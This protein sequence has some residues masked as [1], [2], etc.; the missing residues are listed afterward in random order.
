M[1]FVVSLVLSIPP[2]F[3][4][5]NR[6]PL[7]GLPPDLTVKKRMVLFLRK[8]RGRQAMAVAGAGT[9]S[10][11]LQLARI[12]RGNLWAGVVVSYGMLAFCAAVLPGAMRLAGRSDRRAAG[13]MQRLAVRA[14]S[15]SP[16]F[17]EARAGDRFMVLLAYLP[18]ALLPQVF[19]LRMGYFL[20]KYSLVLNWR[21]AVGETLAGYAVLVGPHAVMEIAALALLASIPLLVYVEVARF[22]AG[23]QGRRAA[24]LAKRALGLR[25]SACIFAAGAAVLVAAAV[26]ETYASDK[27]YMR[28]DRGLLP[29][30]VEQGNGAPGGRAE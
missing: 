20:G 15:R 3:F 13:W 5:Q 25:R 11:Q 12:L 8:E 10:R 7:M 16:G 28:F 26:V 18:L 2:M 6:G 9:G 1:G 27:I 24:G 17:R 14:F 23:E 4:P 22:D 21:G 30:K 19:L 29:E